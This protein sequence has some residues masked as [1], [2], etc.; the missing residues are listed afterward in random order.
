MILFELLLDAQNQ[1]L[2]DYFDLVSPDHQLSSTQDVVQKLV[3]EFLS[4]WLHQ[5]TVQYFGR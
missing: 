1:Q 5:D 2:T 3:S 4:S